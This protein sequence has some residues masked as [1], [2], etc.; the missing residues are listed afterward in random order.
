MVPENRADDERHEVSKFNQIRYAVSAY[1]NNLNTHP[2]YEEFRTERAKQ[3]S[4]IVSGTISGIK[5]IKHD[6]KYSIK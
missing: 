6:H 2:F 4:G 5:L 1:K 3:R